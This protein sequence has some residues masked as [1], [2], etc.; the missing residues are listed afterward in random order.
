MKKTNPFRILQPSERWSPSQIQLDAFQNAYEKLLPPLVY[1]IRLSVSAWRENNYSGASETSKALLKFWFAEEHFIGQNLFR[2]FF[3]Q[4]EAIEQN[5]VKSP[6]LPDKESRQKLLEKDSNDFVERYRDFI[7]LGYLEWEKEYT[8]LQNHKVPILFIMTM[9]TKEADLVA[10]FLESQ[11]PLMKNSV[12][13]IHT[14]NS[15]E[16]KDNT[17]KKDKED[18]ENLRKAADDID[19]NIFFRYTRK[20]QNF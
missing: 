19:K 15:G 2:F 18:L 13:V 4:R 14:N 5:V 8:A 9:N 20:I 3:S 16:I 11:Y 17:S 10:E 12:L 1:K 7:H 6:V